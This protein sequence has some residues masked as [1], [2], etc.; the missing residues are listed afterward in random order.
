MAAEGLPSPEAEFLTN[1]PLIERVIAFVVH[2][3]H[4]SAAD[5]E[6][7]AS[8]VKLKLIEND[9]AVFRKFQNRS[10]LRTYLSTVVTHFFQDFRNAAWGKWRPSSDAVRGGPVA[11]L[12]E[13]LLVRDGYTFDEACELLT[14][15]H[16]IDVART[17]LEELVARLPVRVRRRFEPDVVLVNAPATTPAPDDVLDA[18][19]RDRQAARAREVL[20]RVMAA[21][22]AQDRLILSLIYSD[23]R[24]V[25]DVARLLRLKQ[26]PLYP[27]IAAM[28]RRLRT[29]LEDEGISASMVPQLSEEDR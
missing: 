1:L 11:V 22:P 19:T 4:V 15:N 21:L 9:Y 28:L 12:L 3:H 20:A 29:A 26:K 16:R 7:F 23:G 14:T 10:S 27:R 6:D 18:S 17:E 5:A 8:Q 24:S 25:A 13:Q 2:R